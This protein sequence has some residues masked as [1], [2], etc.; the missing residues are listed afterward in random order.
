MV[1]PVYC[2]LVLVLAGSQAFQPDRGDLLAEEVKSL[3]IEMEDLKTTIMTAL[4][5][6]NGNSPG[7]KRQLPGENGDV[8]LTEQ[9][10]TSACTLGLRG[11]SG[12]DGRDGA[13]GRDGAAG[14][15]GQ[16]G[17]Q[18]PIGEKGD[19]G[20]EVRIIANAFGPQCPQYTIM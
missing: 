11:P 10:D 1:A 4:G 7:T 6:L 3:K 8:G 9:T 2:F 13:P 14:R 20:P 18:G 16:P 12:R 19:I 15:D 5:G 17:L